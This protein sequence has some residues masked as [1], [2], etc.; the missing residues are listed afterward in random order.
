MDAGGGGWL[1]SID[2]EGGL[3]DRWTQVGVTFDPLSWRMGPRA[4]LPRT[5]SAVWQTPLSPSL[6]PL[7]GGPLQPGAHPA[8][9]HR[10]QDGVPQEPGPPHEVGGGGG[11]VLRG[12]G[13][14]LTAWAGVRGGGGG[15]AGRR[16]GGGGKGRGNE[17]RASARGRGRPL[18][19][20]A[21]R[22]GRFRGVGRRSVF[23]VHLFRPCRRPTPP[24]PAR[25]HSVTHP[26]AR[27]PHVQLSCVG[28]GV[29]LVVDRLSATKR[30]PPTASPHKPPLATLNPPLP[31][32]PRPHPPFSNAA[33]LPPPSTLKA[34]PHPLPTQPLTNQKAVPEERARA[35]AQLPQGRALRHPRG[36]GGHLH[37]HGALAGEQEVR[38]GG[39]WG[40]LGGGLRGLGGLL[41]GEIYTTVPNPEPFTPQLQALSIPGRARFD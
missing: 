29:S 1:V 19:G 25:R 27:A 17:E 23:S 24:R 7:P 31:H 28:E 2:V 36:G 37:H 14:L 22:D 30:T 18:P 26:R 12:E 41:G 6:P 4:G 21:A 33:Q 39:F 16:R 15:K 13:G 32:N 20:R 5:P 34:E 8:G 10:G 40:R 9:R 3:G 38:A 35:A 11:A